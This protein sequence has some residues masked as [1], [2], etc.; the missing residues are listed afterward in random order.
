MS[1]LI[2]VDT[3]KTEINEAL[4][5]NYKIKEERIKSLAIKGITYDDEFINIINGKIL[6]LHG[7]N[8][9]ID[10]QSIIV[11]G[12]TETT[13]DG[14]I[15]VME[16]LPTDSQAMHYRGKFIVSTAWGVTIAV[17]NRITKRWEDGHGHVI[18]L[19]W[20]PMPEPY[21]ESDET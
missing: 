1:K 16:R 3:L 7:I 15:P 2:D 14:W 8:N 4:K 10:S 9:F 18:V 20:M 21:K 5:N 12:T 6:A 19:A 13:S 11:S 17:Y